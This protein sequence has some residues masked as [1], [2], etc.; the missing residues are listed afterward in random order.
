M[1]SAQRGPGTTDSQTLT[2]FPSSQAHEATGDKQ[3]EQSI[4]SGW[5]GPAEGR[6]SAVQTNSSLRR[7]V[8]SL[9]LHRHGLALKRL[10]S[11]PS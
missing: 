4:L 9:I 1:Q 7:Q 2:P 5:Q 10:S 6:G 8:Q 3:A 11:A